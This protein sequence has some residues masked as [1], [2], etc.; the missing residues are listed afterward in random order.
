MRQVGKTRHQCVL[1]E[2]GRGAQRAALDQLHNDAA[3]LLE[4]RSTLTAVRPNKC[5]PPPLR[6]VLSLPPEPRTLRDPPTRH[7]RTLTRM[8]AG[9]ATTRTSRYSTQ[10]PRP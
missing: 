9:T 1:Y 4:T 10:T 7:A 5:A 3:T 6:P 8:R 2:I